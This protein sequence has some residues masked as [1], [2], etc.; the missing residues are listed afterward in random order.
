MG[1]GDPMTMRGP[2]THAPM[3]PGS[4]GSAPPA[5]A[6][7]S[8][9]ATIQEIVGILET[10]PATDWSKVDVDA[11]ASALVDMNAVTLEAR[12]AN[13]SVD[14]GMRFEVTGDGPVQDSI[15]RMVVA[16][17]ATMSGVDGWTFETAP[18]AGG[19]SL[20]VR[21]TPPSSRA[22]ILWHAHARH[23]PSEASPHLRGPEREDP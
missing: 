21:R 5:E 4:L 1:P 7:Q 19:A 16:H 10:D 12:V 18:I 14:G 22:R 2:M 15:R 17:A 8:A 6:G 11:P 9:F 20:T 23:A 3:T 13:A